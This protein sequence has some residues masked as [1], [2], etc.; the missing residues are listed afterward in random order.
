MQ[1]PND[2]HSDLWLHARSF[3]RA[4]K[5]LATAFEPHANPLTEFNVCPVVFMYRH[6][7]ELHLKAI[8]LGEG[9]NFL[10]TLSIP[11]DVN[12]GFRRM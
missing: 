5:K 10:A 9:G 7:L 3:H 11:L 6:A 2:S 4:A 12:N 8:I 1:S